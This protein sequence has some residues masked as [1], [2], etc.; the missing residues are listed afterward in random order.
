VRILVFEEIKD[1]EA[2]FFGKL[3][4]KDILKKKH[5]NVKIL[6]ERVKRFNCWVEA[7]VEIAQNGYLILRDTEMNEY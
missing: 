5:E 7:S 1:N 2:G 3:S 6:L 4:V